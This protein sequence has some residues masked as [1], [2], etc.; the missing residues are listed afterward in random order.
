M[1]N[2]RPFQEPTGEDVQNE[3]YYEE[4]P[5][6]LFMFVDER[7]REGHQRIVRAGWWLGGDFF[8]MAPEC[9]FVK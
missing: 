7:M 8:A 1:I 5:P 9:D 2:W 4:T 3:L 6:K